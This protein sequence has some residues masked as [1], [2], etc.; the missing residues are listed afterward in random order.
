[1]AYVKK[2]VVAELEQ[3]Y[4]E[5]RIDLSD[6]DEFERSGYSLTIDVFIYAFA[7]LKRRDMTLH[8]VITS[9][10]DIPMNS[11]NNR[12]YV[13]AIYRVWVDFDALVN[14]EDNLLV[15]PPHNSS[16]W[17]IGFKKALID[18]V[19]SKGSPVILDADTFQ[20][21]D[22]LVDKSSI[23]KPVA[24]FNLIE[25]DSWTE[26]VDT[27]TGTETSYGITADVLFD[28][29]YSRRIRVTGE[30]G[31]IVRNITTK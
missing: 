7:Q 14:R 5:G 15:N 4:L 12:V 1:M 22:F 27:L 2:T 11:H 18:F 16:D 6:F 19:I 28:S 20:W 30:L 9:F 21:E 8:E 25:N 29:G 13:E 10:Q 31:E 23:G 26:F 24:V 17:R 3:A